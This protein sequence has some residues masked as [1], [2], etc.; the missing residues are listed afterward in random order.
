MINEGSNKD[1][2]KGKA[3]RNLLLRRSEVRHWTDLVS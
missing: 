3:Y 2:T 1:R